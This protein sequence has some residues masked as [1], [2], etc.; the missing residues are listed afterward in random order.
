MKNVI[1]FPKILPRVSSHAAGNILLSRKHAFAAKKKSHFCTEQS[2]MFSFWSLC[3]I[4]HHQ[5]Q[6]AQDPAERT[7]GYISAP[8][9]LRHLSCQSPAGLCRSIAN[10]FCYLAENPTFL[11]RVA[12]FTPAWNSRFPSLSS[13]SSVRLFNQKVTQCCGDQ[14]I[15][16]LCYSGKAFLCRLYYK[17]SRYFQA[18]M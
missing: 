16:D 2:N 6:R 9:Q 5:S 15:F 7:R 8:A 14:K 10:F 18:S 13:Y 4:P 11:G 17:L 12:M 3:G 1:I